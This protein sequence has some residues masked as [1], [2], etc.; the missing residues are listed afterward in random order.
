[1]VDRHKLARGEQL[2]PGRRHQYLLTSLL[3]SEP[4]GDKIRRKVLVLYLCIGYRRSAIRAVVVWSS[5]DV[6]EPLVPELDERPLG[7]GPVLLGIGPVLVV[8]IS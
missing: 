8:E 5:R 7:E 2:W 1:M 3:H 6:D 4:V